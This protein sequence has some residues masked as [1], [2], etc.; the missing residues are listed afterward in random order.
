MLHWW[1][2]GSSTDSYVDVGERLLHR[3]ALGRLRP[4]LFEHHLVT[5]PSWNVAYWNLATRAADPGRRRCGPGGRPP[6]DVRPPLRLLAPAAAPAEQAPGHQPRVLLSEDPVLREHLRRLRRPPHCRGVRA[7][8]H[9]FVAP[10]TSHDGVGIDRIIRRLVRA[11]IRA[12]SIGKGTGLGWSDSE[13][14]IAGR[15]ARR[16]R[17]GT[18]RRVQSR[19]VPQRAC[20]GGVP[21]SRRHIPEVGDGDIC[22]LPRV[23]ARTSAARDG[24]PAHRCSHRASATG[25]PGAS[26]ATGRTAD[27]DRPCQA[28][29]WWATSTPTSASA[30]PRV[31]SW[32]ASAAGSRCRPD[33]RPH[34]QPQGRAVD[35]PPVRRRAPAT[36]RR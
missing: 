13:G 6:V 24:N 23:G 30:R 17:S 33:V 11:E 1:S 22:R 28:W 9:D 5:D 27:A 10:F 29:R 18:T 12:E 3:P 20:T 15:V 14:P 32:R 2:S 8:R 35:R 21:I 16:P 34:A 25:T 26:N 7:R 36:T 31:S 19:S 4:G